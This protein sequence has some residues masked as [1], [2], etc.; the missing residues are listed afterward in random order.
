MSVTRQTHK[1][2]GFTIVELL[3]VIVV[4]AILA[5]ISIV[6]YNG[7]QQRATDS[8]RAQDFSSIYKAILAYEIVNNGVPSTVGSGSYTQ[9]VYYGGWDTSISPNWLAFLRPTIG[10]VPIDPQN[11]LASSTNPTLTTNRV[12]FYYCYNAGSGPLPATAN[13]RM[14]YTTGGGQAIDKRFAVT[15]CLAP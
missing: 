11:T 9:G 10:S 3:I 8:R 13:V 5:A 6:A 1:Q 7:I 12:Y 4:I 2:R 14:G 15:Q